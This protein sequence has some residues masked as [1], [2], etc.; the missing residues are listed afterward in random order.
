[1]SIYSKLVAACASL[2][3]SGYALALG[4]ETRYT[5][6][7]YSTQG[8]C[9]KSITDT[10]ACPG[11]YLTT[12]NTISGQPDAYC[13]Q[14]PQ[15][16][17]KSTDGT[18]LV[19]GGPI[20]AAKYFDPSIVLVQGG[21]CQMFY[22]APFDGTVKKNQLGMYY[23]ASPSYPNVTNILFRSTVKNAS[24]YY[25][26]WGRWVQMCG[27]SN[28]P[29]P[30]PPPNNGTGETPY[31]GPEYDP[32]NK[33][34]K[35][36]QDET[37]CPGGYLTTPNMGDYKAYC[38]QSPQVPVKKTD[39]NIK[40]A[41]GIV[42]AST[43]F[44]VG[45]S[46]TVYT[47]PPASGTV[48]ANE[49]GQGYCKM[50]SHP[51]LSSILF[52]SESGSPPEAWGRW[53]KLCTDE[54]PPEPP[55]VCPAGS[56]KANSPYFGDDITAACCAPPSKDD[57]VDGNRYWDGAQ[58]VNKCPATSDKT[59][60]QT[61][62]KGPSFAR[63]ATVAETGKACCF[64]GALTSK[65]GEPVTYWTGS[66]CKCKNG[67]TSNYPGSDTD[68]LK[69]CYLCPSDSSNSYPNCICQ[70]SGEAYSP[71]TGNRTPGDIRGE[72]RLPNKHLRQGQ[73]R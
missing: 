70:Q 4:G 58:C 37:L 69:A 30:D 71:N 43:Q 65:N 64:M 22:G 14:S 24:G 3:I 48:E 17:V 62:N 19:G 42:D 59:G 6:S 8:Q 1:M 7:Q 63:P 72:C 16:A 27:D 32:A 56:D 55:K 11:G 66:E 52:R 25:E 53:V 67:V 38:Y 2:L 5:G 47:N 13:Y 28:Y 60:A 20:D 45:G 29:I 9:L 18:I 36:I 15:V 50:P 12:P 40:I 61:Y 23:C 35:S 34:L 31:N 57:G 39:G 33:C 41:G 44:Q 46:C 49:L 68:G 21:K 54:K 73:I 51:G 10:A 26:A